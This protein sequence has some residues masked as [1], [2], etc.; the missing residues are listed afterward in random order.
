MEENL[1]L[2]SYNILKELYTAE[3]P[4]LKYEQII[5]YLPKSRKISDLEERY[6]LKSLGY[7]IRCF[8]SSLFVRTKLGEYI[9]DYISKRNLANKDFEKIFILGG[10][11]FPTKARLLYLLYQIT[12]NPEEMFRL[13]LAKL[14]NREL[15]SF[16]KSALKVIEE[17]YFTDYFKSK[18]IYNDAVIIWNLLPYIN[19]IIP[20]NE[21]GL[22]NNYVRTDDKF[23]GFDGLFRNTT[24]PIEGLLEMADTMS[25]ELIDFA[26]FMGEKYKEISEYMKPIFYYI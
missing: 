23:T 11:L 18:G 12:K 22:I 14:Y 24:I 15:I 5:H 10:L 6:L 19:E 3:I 8:S 4:A 9:A 16:E 13:L 2:K 1:F 20:F 17:I 26:K 25:E 7:I 21:F